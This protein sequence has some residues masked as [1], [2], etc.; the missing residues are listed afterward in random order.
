MHTVEQKGMGVGRIGCRSDSV[1]PGVAFREGPEAT[2][3]PSLIPNVRE[4]RERLAWITA[5]VKVVFL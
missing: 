1:R 3:G 2:T 4:L 5:A